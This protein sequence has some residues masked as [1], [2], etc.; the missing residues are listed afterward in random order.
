MKSVS[1][2][3]VKFSIFLTL[4]ILSISTLAQKKAVVDYTPPK[5]YGPKALQEDFLIFRKTLET[6]YPSLYRYADSVTINTY[7]DKQFGLLNRPMDETEFYKLIAL[8]CARLNDE[9]LIAKLSP[10]YFKNQFFNKVKIFPFTFKIINRRFYIVKSA[11]NPSPIKPG[12][13]LISIN[14]RSMEE[15]LTRLLPAIPADGYIQTFKIRHLEDYSTTQEENL[16]DI[17]Y[18]LFVE[19]ATSF[20]LE[21]IPVDEPTGKQTVVVAGLTRDEYRKFYTER[22]VL[23]KPLTFTYLKEDVA[24]LK[25]SSFLGWHRRAFKQNFDSLYQVVFNELK[26]KNTPHLILDLRNNEGGDGTGEKLIAYLLQKPYRHFDYLEK[27][28]I[29]L[30]PVSTYLESGN[31]LYV[32]DSM[33][34]KTATGSYRPKPEYYRR[35]TPLLLEQQPK[36]NH[37]NGQL[38]VLANG[39]SGSMA[40]VVCSFLKSNQR[41]VFVGEE[42]GG[43]MEG[44]TARS[45]T[46]LTLPNTHIS[47]G[48][49]LTKTVNAVTYTKGRGVIPDYWIEP[50]IDDLLHGVDTELNFALKLIN[51]K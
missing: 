46:K 18:P 3:G 36:A 23:E 50:T 47:I 35:W 34:Y 10:D 27:K 21:Y 22:R 16:F 4:L 11:S 37:F 31:Q 12:S 26:V 9:H 20:R 2:T 13:E 42:T 17:I 14:G 40:A 5:Q 48:V 33:V 41:A 19:E 49:P 38:T 29:G 28:Y 25:I 32:A 39:A 7:L 51:Q 8:S 15:I 6:T 45:F 44:P 24:Y 43:A 1:L 30:P